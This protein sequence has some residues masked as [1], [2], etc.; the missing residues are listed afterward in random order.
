ML[1]DPIFG[2]YQHTAKYNNGTLPYI[3]FYHI[4]VEGSKQYF[5]QNVETG[6]TFG[7]MKM[8]LCSPGKPCNQ[9][10]HYLT[11]G[12]IRDNNTFNIIMEHDDGRHCL[13]ATLRKIK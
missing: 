11:F 8:I 6:K 3:N 7:P 9:S 12:P 13:D 4:I 1:T 5:I 10:N 2:S